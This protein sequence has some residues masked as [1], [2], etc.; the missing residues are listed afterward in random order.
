ML[1][2]LPGV[3]RLL[4]H[5][6]AARLVEQ[7]GRPLTVEALRTALQNAREN[8]LA[9]GEHVPSSA[10]LIGEAQEILAG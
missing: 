10:V 9:G 8:I 1:K 6:T 7:Y 2:D 4:G 3:D 5:L